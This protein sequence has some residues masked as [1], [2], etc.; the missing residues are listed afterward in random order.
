MERIQCP[1]G[2]EDEI[3]AKFRGRGQYI[4]EHHLVDQMMRINYLKNDLD[5]VMSNILLQKNSLNAIGIG[6]A[7]D[8]VSDLYCSIVREQAMALRLEEIQKDYF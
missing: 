4:T 7:R 6:R 1:E 3:N 2:G 5:R 8:V